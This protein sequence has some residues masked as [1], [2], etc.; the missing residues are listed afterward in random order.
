MPKS[1]AQKLK[2]KAKRQ[3][4]RAAVTAVQAAVAPVITGKGKYKI[5]KN[6]VPRIMGKGGY[7]DDALANLKHLGGKALNLG[8]SSLSE[9]LAPG[10]GEIASGLFKQITGLGKYKLRKNEL[11]GKMNFSHMMMPLEAGAAVARPP[12]FGTDGTGSDILFSH[13]EYVSDILSSVAFSSTVYYINPG[14]PVLFPWLSQLASLYE[15]YDFEGLVF[16]YRPTSGTSVNSSTGAVGTVLMATEYDVYDAGFS[17]KREMDS[18]EYSSSGTQYDTFLHPIECDPKRNVIRSNYVIPG[19]NT[20]TGIPGDARMDFLGSMSVATTGQGANGASI[21]ELWVSYK[22]RLSRPVLETNLITSNFTQHTTGTVAALNTSPVILTNHSAGG[23]PFGISISGTSTSM[24]FTIN[25]QAAYT[26]RYL[27]VMGCWFTGSTVL[28]PS[29]SVQALTG[30]ATVVE[31]SAG[32][33]YVRGTGNDNADSACHSCV[34]NMAGGIL[35]GVQIGTF[36]GSSAQ[37]WDIWI[38]PFNEFLSKSRKIDPIGDRISKLEQLMDSMKVRD[39]HLNTPFDVL[40]DY[41]SLSS[42]SS[43]TL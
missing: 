31:N 2:R 15:I 40:P 35:D 5:N 23:S 1:V 7:W 30:N 9:Y 25:N 17:N 27:I 37:Q 34:I 11:H 21:G 39:R 22:V 16:E 24:I 26:G 8:A 18:A 13:S 14:N 28:T 19:L 12:S 32:I 29:G 3:A 42:S 33:Q 38:T 41:S 36:Y 43:S 10:T 4:K 20:I 6:R